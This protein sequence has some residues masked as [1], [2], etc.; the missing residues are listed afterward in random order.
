MRTVSED[1]N[2]FNGAVMTYWTKA[3][4]K[5][6]MA[7]GNPFERHAQVNFGEHV[8]IVMKEDPISSPCQKA[9]Y[10]DIGQRTTAQK[11]QGAVVRG[12]RE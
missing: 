9:Q 1:V 12:R 10:Y 8:G 2:Q 6:Q 3:A 7:R 11:H 4:G 5:W